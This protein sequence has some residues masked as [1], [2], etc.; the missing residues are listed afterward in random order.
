MSEAMKATRLLPLLLCLS[1][2]VACSGEST[3]TFS[4]AIGALD[5][6]DAAL[7][8]KDVPLAIAAY[9]YASQNGD[10]GQRTDALRGLLAVQLDIG[11]SAASVQAFENLAKNT[12]L[13]TEDLLDLANACV[14]ARLVDPAIAVVDY[15]TASN[16]G[17]KATFARPAA[18]IDLLQSQGPG[19]DLSSLGYTGD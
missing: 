1:P 17:I 7:A 8:A 2:L 9:E 5:K 15:A 14:T 18:A 11:E 4:S 12:S 13:S 3:P 19:A 6:G 16:E 10:E